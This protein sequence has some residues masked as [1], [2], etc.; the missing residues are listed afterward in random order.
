M[1]KLIIYLLTCFCFLFS[2][3]GNSP[4]RAQEYTMVEFTQESVEMLEYEMGENS[5]YAGQYLTYAVDDNNNIVRVENTEQ[6]R[7][8]ASIAVFIGG[9]IVGYLT[10][11]VI[12]GVVIAVTGQSGAWWCAQAI[13]NVLN[14]PYTGRTYINCNVYPPNSYE[15]AICNRYH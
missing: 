4:V 1:K 9:V 14:R 10:A 7:S 15:V 3:F 2:D 11:T 13:T 8:L 12:D 6:T 5:P